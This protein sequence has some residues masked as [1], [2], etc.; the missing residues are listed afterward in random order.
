[1]S[2]LESRESP[3]KVMAPLCLYRV[4]KTKGLIDGIGTVRLHGTNGHN[5]SIEDYV[6]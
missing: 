6:V 3:P 5:G 1:M 2:E 4:E